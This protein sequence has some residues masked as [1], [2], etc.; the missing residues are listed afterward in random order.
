MKDTKTLFSDLRK[1]TAFSNSLRR[2]FD[3]FF[4]YFFFEGLGMGGG[5]VGSGLFSKLKIGKVLLCRCT[6]HSIRWERG[7]VTTQA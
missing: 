6:P 3:Y 5:G 7:P 2:L 4:D 1:F